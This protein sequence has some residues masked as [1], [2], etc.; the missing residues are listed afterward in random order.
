MF[1]ISELEKIIDYP[2]NYLKLSDRE[3]LMLDLIK[4][5]ARQVIE[6]AKELNEK[7]KKPCDDED[8]DEQGSEIDIY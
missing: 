7:D 4:Q 5:L 1:N 3:Y 8:Y 2:P 6:L